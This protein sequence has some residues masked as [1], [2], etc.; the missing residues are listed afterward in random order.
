MFSK[1]AIGE[2][3]KAHRDKFAWSRSLKM[4]INSVFEKYIIIVI[5]IIIIIIIIH[6]SKSKLST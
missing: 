4:I 5:I 1:S 6:K 3:I 2:Y